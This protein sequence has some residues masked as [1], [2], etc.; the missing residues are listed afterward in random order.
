MGYFGDKIVEKLCV[1]NLYWINFE[2]PKPDFVFIDL[3]KIFFVIG[4]QNKFGE[5]INFFPIF[6]FG[7]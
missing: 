3:N 2:N 6:S 5:K 1:F 7:F 4:T